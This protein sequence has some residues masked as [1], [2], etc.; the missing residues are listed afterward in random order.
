[1]T[2][3]QRRSL[4]DMLP[5][6]FHCHRHSR[7][8]LGRLGMDS[9]LGS[10]RRRS[11]QPGINNYAVKRT[12]KERQYSADIGSAHSRHTN[13]QQGIGCSMCRRVK[14]RTPH[15]TPTNSPWPWSR[16]RCTSRSRGRWCRIHRRGWLRQC[17]PCS[18]TSRP[19][20]TQPC[21][22][23]RWRLGSRNSIHMLCR[24]CSWYWCM[25]WIRRN[26]H[27]RRKYM[28]A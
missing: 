25:A 9:F 2:P 3:P 15:C 7:I 28:V 11:I 1:M 14:G 24:P 17:M 26:H 8:R 5:I 27:C 19:T 22:P 18:R 4:Q 16:R 23:W 20:C 21:R 13:C 6:D 12:A 10:N